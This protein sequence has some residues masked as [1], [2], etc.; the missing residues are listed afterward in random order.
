L[1]TPLETSEARRITPTDL[2]LAD[3]AED[4]RIVA[5]AGG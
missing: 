5:P 2:G 3:E 1:S 4:I